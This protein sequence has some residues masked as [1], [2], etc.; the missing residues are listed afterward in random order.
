MRS[1]ILTVILEEMV[2]GFMVGAW[3]RLRLN[4]KMD[5]SASLTALLNG[6]SVFLPVP[7]P[8][9]LLCQLFSVDSTVALM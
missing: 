5:L 2:E 8:E 6:F 3:T 4:N 9:F 1:S 7:G